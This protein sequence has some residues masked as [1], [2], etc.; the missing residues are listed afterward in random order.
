MS[1]FS[2]PD[3][4]PEV[5]EPFS[6]TVFPDFLPEEPEPLS[7]AV[8]EPSDDFGS[9]APVIVR[10]ATLRRLRMKPFVDVPAKSGRNRGRHAPTIPR[11]DSM[12][13]QSRLGVSNHVMSKS[14]P[15]AS[16]MI[17]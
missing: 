4:T 17:W 3:C 13:V 5:F 6:T 14:P 1:V 9:S 11:A 2:E 16:A 12:N 10:M 8:V 15:A 7:T